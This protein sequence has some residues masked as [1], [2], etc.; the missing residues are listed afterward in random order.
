MSITAWFGIEKPPFGFDDTSLT[1]QQDEILQTLRVHSQQGGMCLVIGEPGT[2]KTVLRN[3]IKAQDPKRI[4]APVISRTLHSY[5]NTLRILC[6]A[7]EVDADRNDYHC[8]RQVID[9][10]VRINREGKMFVPIVDDA[11]LMDAHTMR[12]LR[13]LL[14]E[15]PK[16]HNLV[17][18]GQPPLMTTLH[19]SVNADIKSRI[20]YS[21]AMPRLNPDQIRQFIL[22]Q[23]DRVRMGHNVFTDDALELIVRSSEG[24]LRRAR[25][26]AIATLIEAIRDKTRTA[27]LKQV[28]AV[29]VQPHYRNPN[30]DLDQD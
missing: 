13:L 29:L 22:S 6:Q 26:L 28:N 14:E 21:V 17:L 25:N 20:T 27:D 9:Y 16:N 5:F 24:V 8:E 15:C 23:L 18:I 1:E 10:A 12:K 30:H 7:C 11:H 2:G 3:A 4:I 19:L